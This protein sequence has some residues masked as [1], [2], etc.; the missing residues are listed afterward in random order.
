FAEESF[1]SAKGIVPNMPSP[2]LLI[3]D[4]EHKER[5]SRIR[6]TLR[7]RGLNALYLT[8]PTR[9]LYATGFAHITT[10]RPL[11]LVVP[12]EGPIFLMGPHL[13]KDHVKQETQIIEEVF[14]YPDYPGKVHPIRNFA[15]ILSSKRLAGAKIAADSLEGAAGGWGYRGPS[16]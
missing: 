15:K 5:I 8:S 13:E 16:I 14:E 2:R 1:N 3:S 12:K 7:R 10:E 6:A 4:R 11:A 9:I